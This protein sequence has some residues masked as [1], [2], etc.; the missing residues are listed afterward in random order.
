MV[1][2]TVKEF[3]SLE[4]AVNNAA[5]TPD[6]ALASEFDEDYW[7]RLMNVELKVSRYR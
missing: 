5:L 7:G 4:V 2:E 3:K 6:N 1:E